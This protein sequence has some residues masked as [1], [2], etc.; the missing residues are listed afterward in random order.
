MLRAGTFA[1]TALLAALSA[2]GPLTTDMYL[3]SLPDIARQLAA[4][5]AQ[6]QLTLSAYLIGFA[7]G[8]IF[9]GPISDRHG[10]KP[11]LIA[12]LA[13]YCAA[14]LAC[15][16]STSVEMLIVAR[17]VQGLGGSGGIV[18]ARAVVRDLFTGARAG[19]ELSVIGSVMGLA[20]VLAPIAGGLLQS[21]FGWR[22]IFVT[23]VIAGM[24]GI[25]VVWLI[26]PET[27]RQRAAERVSPK[28]MLAAYRVV[29]RHP[30]YLAYLALATTSYAGLFAWISGASFVL[31]DL[32]GL[33]PFN[34]GVAFALGSVGYMAGATLSA[35]LVMRI[36]IDGT[37]GVG[38]AMLAIGGLGMVATVA[39]GLKS[40]FLLVLPVSIYLA[41]LGM[42]LPQSI[43]GAMS[44]F[45]DRA[46][47]ASSLLGFIQQSGAALCGAFVGWML[48]A[49][50]WP[51]VLTVAAMGCATFAIWLATQRLRARHANH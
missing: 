18:L 36:G 42:V 47:A 30:A 37:L 19:R 20:P 48:G 26:L 10:R 8:Q 29:A 7:V 17:F 2:V 51:L 12:A 16:L 11:V 4:S 1:L 25:V 35:R 9:Y 33:N 23:L 5:T 14:S 50:A 46:G 27:L 31:Q 21:A 22:V 34:F 24:I 49:N 32:Y 44:P 28:S 38:A 41:G 13:L 43:A 39:L 6:V 15:A 3:P 45:P 40:P